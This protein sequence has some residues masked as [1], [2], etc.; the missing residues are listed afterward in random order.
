MDNILPRG[1]RRRVIN[2]LVI[3]A[4]ALAT[5]ISL[6]QHDAAAAWFTIDFVLVFAAALMLLQARDKT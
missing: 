3:A 1:R 2:G 4:L 6:V 5:A